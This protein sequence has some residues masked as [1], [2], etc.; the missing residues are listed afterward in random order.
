MYIRKTTTKDSLEVLNLYRIAIQFMREHHNTVQW[1]NFDDLKASILHDI[2]NGD[3]YVL[4]DEEKIQAC[5]SLIDGVEESYL[6]I[7]GSWKDD[8]AY[9][10]IHRLAVLT[11]H[12]GYG[13]TCL[14]YAFLSHR[15]LRID[16]HETNMPMRALIEKMG[17]EYCGIVTLK[18]ETKRFAYEKIVDFSSRLLSWYRLNKRVFP[19]RKDHDF[20]H[21]YLSEIMLQQTSTYKVVEYYDRFLNTF[22]TF[23]SLS[24]ASE[25]V[26]MKLWQGLG[27]YSRVKNLVKG[28]KYLCAHHEDFS[29]ITKEELLLVPGIGQ[30][31]ANAILAIS[32]DQ[33]QIA[34][35]G[36]LFRIF[37]RLTCYDHD[38]HEKNSIL[39]CEQFYLSR[40]R[41]KPSLFNQALMDLGELICLPH[42][43]PHCDS[44]PLKEECLSYKNDVVLKYPLKVKKNP[45]KEVQLTVFLLRYQDEYVIYKRKDTGLLSSLYEFLNVEGSLAMDEAKQ[46]L[47]SS[48]FALSSI[49]AM[50]DSKHVFTHL[51]WKMK[52]YE[53]VLSSLPNISYIL[54]SRDEILNKYSFPSAF[55]LFLEEIEK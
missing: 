48:G 21:V 52:G 46:Y 16:T 19:W 54:A 36:N 9:S 1:T 26:Y 31:T 10:T 44:C 6:N 38:V 29:S 12:R 4:I 18:D 23:K 15:H 51:V 55:H 3:S 24:L 7:D 28:A 14:C 8:S 33:K 37:A 43:Q 20:Y 40:L 5:F 22:P 45:K 53:V 39:D 49:R 25:D 50:D 17:F 34:V 13:V 32:Y 41:Q 47:E 2:S 27:Y 30:Y 35:D 42:G 11:S